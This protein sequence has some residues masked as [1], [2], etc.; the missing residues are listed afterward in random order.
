MS[1]GG[2]KMRKESFTKNVKEE[3]ALFDS[4][5]VSEFKALLSGF[6]KINGNLVVRQGK[7]LVSI[8]SEN[9]KVVTLIYKKIKQLYPVESRIII[10]E[11]KKLRVS[12]DN[13]I[14]YLEI[15]NGV[16]DVLSD[17]EI[18]DEQQ[19]FERLP[20][21]NFLKGNEERK[22]YFA[23]AF[24]ASGSV[25]SPI[26]KNYH[27]EIAVNNLD[28]AQ[29]LIRLAKKFNLEMKVIERRKQYVVYLKKSDQIADFL[30]IIG[31]WQNL[32]AYEEQ[33]IQRDQYNSINRIYNCDIS[34][35]RRA[36]ANGMRQQEMIE[37]YSKTFGLNRLSEPLRIVAE[38]RLENP[39]AA[40]VELT[41]YIYQ[42]WHIKLSKPGL[43]YRLKKVM[44]EIEKW[45][46]NEQ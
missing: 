43:S 12:G 40:Y 29:Y 28:Y 16:K 19:G 44:E 7:W 14:F 32:F 46:T 33:R 30:N 10:T 41:E 25:N 27:L 6:I 18:Y 26:N 4:R 35:E 3:V 5:S 17:L 37:W 36:M 20:S 13:K 23:G 21:P 9:V 8:R 22:A 31:A 39:E 2:N 15:E 42:K 45:R 11:K 1:K 34:N 24:L 38:A